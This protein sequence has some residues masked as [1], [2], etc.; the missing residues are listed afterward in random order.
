MLPISWV[1]SRNGSPSLPVTSEPKEDAGQDVSS[2]GRCCA[3]GVTWIFRMSSTWHC[4]NATAEP[5]C[6]VRTEN[7]TPPM[8]KE[9]HQWRPMWNHVLGVYRLWQEGTTRGCRWQFK[10]T[11]VHWYTAWSSRSIGRWYLW[12]SKYALCICIP[13]G[14]CPAPHCSSYNHMAG[15][16]LR[17]CHGHRIVPIWTSSSLCGITLF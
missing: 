13:A 16:T 9:Q 4:L 7:S 8:S 12:P 1:G 10:Q 6:G 11:P 3:T 15:E 17:S 14:Q 5:S 2:N